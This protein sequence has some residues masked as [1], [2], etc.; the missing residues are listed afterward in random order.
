MKELFQAVSRLYAPKGALQMW[1][2]YIAEY[3]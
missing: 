2:P 1:Q 3:P